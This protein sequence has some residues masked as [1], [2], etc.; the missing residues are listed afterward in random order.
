MLGT[1]HTIQETEM[2][3]ILLAG[4]ARVGKT[5]AA[6]E[7][8]KICKELGLN[9]VILPFAKAIKDEA[10]A[11]GLSK[12]ANPELYRSYC[13]TVGGARRLIEPDHWVNMFNAAWRQ[14]QAAE[15]KTLES[16]TTIFEETVVIVDDCRYMNELNYAKSIG[17]ITVFI[18][19]GGRVLEDAN[20]AWRQHESEDLANQFE[21]G[22]KDYQDLFEWVMMN[23]N[24]KT[25]FQS[26]LHSRVVAWTNADPVSMV[27]CDCVSCRLFKKDISPIEAGWY[28][29]LTSLLESDDDDLDDIP[30]IV[31]DLFGDLEDDAHD[32]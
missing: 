8:V 16:A 28:N 9:P 2:I 26:K 32:N 25:V 13:Q 19:D 23:G 5:T 1:S 15:A 22:N 18:S 21:G 31:E 3:T 20:G 27:G 17:A 6:E 11:M 14:L 12:E 30:E 7:I 29:M 24:S 4:K 10:L